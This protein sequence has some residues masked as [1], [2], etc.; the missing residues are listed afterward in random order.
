[1]KEQQKNSVLAMQ[2]QAKQG[3]LQDAAA[4]G[5]SGGGGTA[6]NLAGLQSATQGQ[7]SSGYAN[8]DISAAETNFNDL[9][10]ASGLSD[11]YQ[12]QLLNQYLQT[13]GLNAGVEQAQAGQNYA[14]YQSQTTAEQNKLQDWL[15]TQ[16][17][18]M[19]V[20]NQQFSQFL[21]EQGIQLSQA[22]LSEMARQF[23]ISESDLM[24]KWMA[25]S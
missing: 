23:G 12:Q 25:G 20:Q 18:G 8:T 10:K 19:G 24:T 1:M 14:G 7:I 4:R 22:Q 15:A 5:V 9:L 16:G 3:I 2:D 6:A 13:Q 11:Q 21:S 17:F